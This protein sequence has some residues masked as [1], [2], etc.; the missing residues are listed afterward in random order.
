MGVLLMWRDSNLD[1]RLKGG[2]WEREIG[3]GLQ[4]HPRWSMLRTH[5]FRASL[6]LLY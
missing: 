6:T 5:L 1:V 3:P 4:R 2:G